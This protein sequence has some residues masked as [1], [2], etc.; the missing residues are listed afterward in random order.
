[1]TIKTA[2]Q[3]KAALTPPSSVVQA[4]TAE[5]PGYWEISTSGRRVYWSALKRMLAEGGEPLDIAARDIAGQP[6]AYRL[7]A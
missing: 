6:C 2:S 4:L 5:R 1:M 3:L 7:K